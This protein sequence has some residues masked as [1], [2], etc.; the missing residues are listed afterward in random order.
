MSNSEEKS[1]HDF[2]SN[3]VIVDINSA[4]KSSIINL[5]KSYRLKLSDSIIIASALHFDLP[6]IT[7]DNFFNEV[8]ELE[9]VYFEKK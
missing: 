1:I 6:L 5:R 7:S 3:R 4:I 2:P 8:E 9:T